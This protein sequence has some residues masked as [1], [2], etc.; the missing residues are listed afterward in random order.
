MMA[1]ANHFPDALSN[2]F[3]AALRTH[4]DAGLAGRIWA[5][6]ADVWP[7]KALDWVG[8]LDAPADAGALEAELASIR[9]HAA[10]FDQAVL[11]GMGGSSMCPE[12]LADALGA[13][14]GQPPLR[15]LDSS[16]PSEVRALRADIDPARTLFIIA[17][18]SGTTMET[19]VGHRYFRQAVSEA[20]GPERAAAHFIAITD[21]GTPL[22]QA[23]G[24]YHIA[25]GQPAIGGRFSALSVFGL[26]PAAV[27]GVDLARLLGSARSMASACHADSEHNPGLRLGVAI[28]T[29]AGLGRDKLTLACSP[30]IAGLGAWAEQ[31]IAEST[32]KGGKGIVP[33]D[34]EPLAQPA[35][36]GDDRI[37]L[38]V[39]LAGD[40]SHD[41]AMQA[42]RDAGQP[43]LRLDVPDAYALGGEFFRFQF[44]TAVAGALMALNPFDQPD[45]EAAKLAARRMM[46][47]GGDVG[48]G[49][50]VLASAGG[51][52]VHGPADSPEAADPAAAVA[53]LLRA[54][55]PGHYIA[56]QAYL[57]RNP[58]RETQLAGLAGT[59]R[60]LTG[61]AVTHG[62]GPR[63]LHSTGQLH[64]GGAANVV[65]IQITTG[66]AD[67]PAVPG[68]DFTFGSLAAAQAAGDF[69]VLAERGRPI[70]RVHL[71]A[72][73]G[74]DL[75]A[76]LALLGPP[77]S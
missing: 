69:E 44:A 54:A 34:L 70:L 61:C 32:G 29:A 56:L 7:G 72:P 45:V 50:R 31:L 52:S 28:A 73:L 68:R 58:A 4:C 60:A 77:Q 23:Q 33:V 19:D 67:D 17:S 43:V 25:A 74:E 8:W 39:R 11:I 27:L 40:D 21:P 13:A 1:N 35:A 51:L 10:G 62:F 30:G 55:T 37:F 3:A 41:A 18:K 46:A 71:E 66:Y 65:C 6:A 63:F 76:L 5:R 64:K 47:A 36:Y 14:P 26:L 15:V 59:L 2:A 57:A 24:F 42:L 20:V 22:S 48:A 12:V 75:G 16:L 53:N 38:H 49:Q 9:A